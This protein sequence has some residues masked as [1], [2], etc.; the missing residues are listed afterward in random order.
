MNLPNQYKKY[1][2]KIIQDKDL[3]SFN[4]EAS[5]V[6]LNIKFFLGSH[7]NLNF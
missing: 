6:R 1:I 4:F 7:N 5:L 2:L 3:V